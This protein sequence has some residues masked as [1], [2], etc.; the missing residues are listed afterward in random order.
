MLAPAPAPPTLLHLPTSAVRLAAIAQAAVILTHM[1]ARQASADPLAVGVHLLAFGSALALA[2]RPAARLAAVALAFYW[3]GR[4]PIELGEAMAGARG[5]SAWVAPAE[6][7]TLACAAAAVAF[8]T[9]SIGARQSRAA[10]QGAV[11]VMLLLFGYIHATEAATI[12]G[13]IPAWFPLPAVA[14][15][16]TATVM[17]LAGAALWI[18]RAMPAAICGVAAMFV[19]WLPVVHAPR[20]AAAP[21]DVGEWAFAAMALALAG[22]LLV[23]LTTSPVRRPGRG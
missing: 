23:L 10:L 6:A 22:S 20:L 1:L 7:L 16:A 15:Y 21:A 5:A 11:S 9:G 18:P 2:Y 13:L 3:L 14:P 8:D 12:A 19:S 17:M 4:F